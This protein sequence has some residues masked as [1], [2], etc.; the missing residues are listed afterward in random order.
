[1]RFVILDFESLVPH[2]N[3]IKT[4]R[5]IGKNILNLSCSTVKVHCV[6]KGENP[7]LGSALILSQ[8]DMLL[9]F[10][11]EETLK[12]SKREC[13]NNYFLI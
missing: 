10:A 11:C 9:S 5:K 2:K 4:L 7:V 8:A 13:T 1:M 6:A 3:M 12:L